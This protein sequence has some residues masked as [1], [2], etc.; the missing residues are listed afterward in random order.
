MNNNRKIKIFAL[1]F[2]ILILIALA[3]FFL[4]RSQTG[5]DIVKKTRDNFPFGKVETGAPVQQGGT[6]TSSET[7]K[8]QETVEEESEPKRAGPRLRQ[9]SDFPTG[10][11]APIIRVEEKEVTDISIDANGVSSQVT[12]MIDVENNYVRYSA[13]DDAS[14]YDS[15]LTPFEI[16]QELL[17][18]NYIPNAEH[19]FFSHDGS[20]ALFQY[21]NSDERVIE[22][23]LG[24][25]KKKELDIKECPYDFTQPIILDEEGEHVLD[26]HEFLNKNKQTR[27]ASSGVNSPG[28]EGSLVVPATITAIKNFQSLY[29]LDIDGKLGPATQK[30]MLEICDTYE[31]IKAEKV[32]AELDTRYGITGSFLPQKLSTVSIKPDGS[33]FFYLKEAKDKVV[34]VVQNFVSNEKKEI[35]SSPYM[36]WLSQWNN[37]NSIEIATKPSYLSSGYSYTLDPSDGDYH[38]S[39]KQKKGLTTLASPNNDYVL[40]FESLDNKST[41]LSVYNRETKQMRPLNIQSFPEKCTWSQGDSPVL[42]CFVPNQLAYGNEYPDIWYQ[43]LETYA[44]SLWKIN[45]KTLVAEIVSDIQDEYQKEFD[46]LKVGIDKNTD[47]LYFIDKNTEHLWSYRL[48]DA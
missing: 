45:P 24:Q 6:Q 23:Y 10:G 15:K 34:G 14:L 21:W 1:I 29:E 42:Y 18:E 36:G 11:F 32:F 20:H 38:K 8:Q 46:A 41:R 27:I 16:T 39:F 2:F 40:A 44:D 17:T 37:D 28:N 22:T 48:L 43:G 25:I 30:K 13:I 47:Y 35:F 9:V 4:L 33:E 19:V 12:K 31:K 5:K 3:V 7:D 26:F